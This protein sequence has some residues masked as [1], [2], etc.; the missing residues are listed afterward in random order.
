MDRTIEPSKLNEVIQLLRRHEY[1]IRDIARIVMM[2][3]RQIHR[4][5]KEH[6]IR[7]K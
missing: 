3:E 2:S 7:V 5:N 4:I 1:S 6:N